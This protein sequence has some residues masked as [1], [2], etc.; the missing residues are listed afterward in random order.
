MLFLDLD[1]FKEI[2]DTYGHETGDVL[3]VSIARRLDE[4]VREQDTVARLGGDEFIL[5]FEGLGG[6]EEAHSLAKRVDALFAEPFVAGGRPF[7]CS[8]S[9]GLAVHRPGDGATAQ[10]MLA[11][12]DMRMY[13]AK[14]QRK[15]SK[16]LSGS[17]A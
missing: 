7:L 4:A 1:G 5:L 12:A 16:A 2:N 17:R 14:A 6:V 8:A 13:E 10:E 3:L 15:T 9:A 11:I